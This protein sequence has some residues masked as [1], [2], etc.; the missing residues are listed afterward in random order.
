MTNSSRNTLVLAILLVVCGVFAFGLIRKANAKLEQKQEV[1][2]KIQEQIKAFEDLV[3]NRDSLEAEYERLMTIASQQSKVILNRD[4]SATT[5]DYLLRVLNWLGNDLIYDFGLSSKAN[6]SYNEY[7]ISGR[8]DY[9]DLVRFTRLL[10]YQRTLLTI[11]DISIAAESVAHSDTV[12]FSMIFRTHY[13]ENGVPAAGVPY[14]RVTKQVASYSLFRPKYTETMPDL[15]KDQAKSID[16]DNSTL[17]ALSEDRAFVRD[18]RGIIRILSVGDTVLW[19]Y[20][21]KIDPREGAAVFKLNKYGFEENQIMY[22]NKKI[23]VSHE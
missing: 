18:N 20:L 7:V 3:A 14:K 17:I 23:E 1:T 8:S 12:S 13:R 5:Y 19:G 10:E 6:D 9:M 15:D 11:E 16:T 4:D 21:Y 22:L 2:K